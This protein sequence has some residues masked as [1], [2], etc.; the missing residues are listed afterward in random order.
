VTARATADGVCL[1]WEGAADG[2]AL[3][4]LDEA[5]RVLL[6]A[7]GA[8]LGHPQDLPLSG[9]TAPTPRT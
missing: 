6:G 9:D 8:L 7:L 2:T 3:G 4:S 5:G 1:T